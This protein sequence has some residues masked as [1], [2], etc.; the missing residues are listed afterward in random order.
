MHELAYNLESFNP[1][2][3]AVL[4]QARARS[5]TASP[6]VS[7]RSEPFTLITAPSPRSASRGYIN[8]VV[9]NRFLAAPQVQCT[10]GRSGYAARDRALKA[11]IQPLAGEYGMHNGEAQGAHCPVCKHA[12]PGIYLVAKLC[13]G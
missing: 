8:Y 7:I 12:C 4:L 11:L 5:S 10:I 2:F 3:T 1:A 9:L 6:V 13:F